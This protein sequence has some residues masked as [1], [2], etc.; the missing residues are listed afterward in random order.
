MADR[1]P[2]PPTPSSSTH[3]QNQHKHQQ[4]PFLDHLEAYLS[5][6]DGVDKLLKISR[7]TSRLILSSSFAPSDPILATRLKEFESSVGASRKAF[8]L[9]KFVQDVNVLLKVP[10]FYSRDGLL[11]VVASGG[12]GIYY[13]IEQF[14]WLIKAGL[15]DKRHNKRLQKFSAWA[16]FIGYFGSVTL[17]FLQVATIREKEVK[18]SLSLP[19]GSGDISEGEIAKKLLELREKRFMKSLSIVQD[20]SDCLLALS[21]IRDGQGTLS[22]PFLLASAGLVSALIST[23]KNWSNC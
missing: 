14:V 5:R 4:R 3:D 2:A 11:E 23:H 7:Y 15:I 22:N 21:D 18:L 19:K 17:K 20:F 12:E 9:G 13:F 10:S 1:Q 16:E 8:R 6:R